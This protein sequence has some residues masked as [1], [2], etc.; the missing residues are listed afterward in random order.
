[1]VSGPTRRKPPPRHDDGTPGTRQH[2]PHDTAIPRS[3]A[4]KGGGLGMMLLELFVPRGALSAGQ[5]RELA[6]RL[7]LRQLLTHVDAIRD[8]VGG[9]EAAGANAGVLDFLD[10]IRHVVVH[11][12]GVWIV[13]EH[14]LDPAGPPRYIGR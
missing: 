12:T 4:A 1:M 6:R 3:T 13:G 8:V 11:E 14:A 10:S 7:T 9:S 2:R 5:L